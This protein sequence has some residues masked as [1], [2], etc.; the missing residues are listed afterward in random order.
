M[1]TAR[2]PESI[3]HK[4]YRGMMLIVLMFLLP[5]LYLQFTRD[6]TP[7]WIELPTAAVFGLYG[8][9]FLL[10]PEREPGRPMR[11]GAA[12]LFLA[13]SAAAFLNF[14]LHVKG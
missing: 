11:Y 7:N 3:L 2:Q 6:R 10:F 8:L 14:I 12:G 13:A 1:A 9:S 5:A 4:L